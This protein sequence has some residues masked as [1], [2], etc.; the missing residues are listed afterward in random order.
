MIY[1]KTYRMFESMQD[2]V[3]PQQR[4]LLNSCC[5]FYQ[6]NRQIVQPENAWWVNPEIGRAHV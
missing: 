5:Q 4:E 1:L 6:K 2:G 3:T